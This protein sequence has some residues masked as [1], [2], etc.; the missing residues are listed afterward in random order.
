MVLSNKQG[1]KQNQVFSPKKWSGLSG[2]TFKNSTLWTLHH[3]IFLHL[4]PCLIRGLRIRTGL[5]MAWAF[6]ASAFL[7][8]DLPAPSAL[9][10]MPFVWIFIP[11][12]LLISRCLRWADGVMSLFSHPVCSYAP[13]LFLLLLTSVTLT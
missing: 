11:C 6:H 5:C 10:K 9:F 1:Q 13:H 2:F 3:G 4:C 7:I 12:L 8:A